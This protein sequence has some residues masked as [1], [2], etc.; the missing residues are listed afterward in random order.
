MNNTALFLEMK[1]EFTEHLVDIL[2]P[3][4][5]EGLTSIYKEAV[6][7]ATETDNNEKTLMIFQKLLQSINN[8]N[9]TKII[10]ETNRIKQ[11]SNTSDYL[12]DLV[13]VVI[14]S[15]IILL[16]YSNSMS[17]IISQSFYNSFSTTTLI[18]RCYTECGKDAH[19]NPYLFFHNIEPMD[20]KRNQIIINSKI[21]DG[22]KRAVR[23]ILPL[24]M[25]LKEFLVNTI[26]ITH[27]MNTKVELLNM[28]QPLNCEAAVNDKNIPNV[29]QPSEIAKL[30]K[31]VMK[32]IESEKTKTEKEKIQAIMNI[33]KI[34]TSIEPKK[35]DVHK[36][37][38]KSID[39]NTRIIQN[40]SPSVKK[41]NS[42]IPLIIN[43]N[44]RN[45]PNLDPNSRSLG[46]NVNE[47][48]NEQRYSSKQN[49][50]ASIT[51][52][53]MM[54]QP[55]Y[56]HYDPESS[57]RIDPDK[58]DLIENYGIPTQRTNKHRTYQR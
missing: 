58:V 30:E 51:T 42:D 23:K 8:W 16:T 2:T 45:I 22:I 10:E 34:L 54:P 49:D 46:I 26:N 35:N 56:T 40:V 19:N 41:R 31:E 5:Y 29:K 1:T 21:Q 7:I 3:F 37:E 52:L 32:M 55:T 15:Y 43:T 53:S 14:K 17:N 28:T 24:P 27:E 47:N 38:P 50:N 44:R 20:F 39:L 36:I 12:D 18:H 11:L 25:I 4:I 13:K 48:S 57:E 9:Q 6:I 33:D